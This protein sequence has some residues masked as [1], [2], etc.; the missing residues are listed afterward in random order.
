VS[1]LFTVEATLLIFLLGAFVTT[2]SAQELLVLLSQ[3]LKLTESIAIFLV[4]S[5]SESASVDSSSDSTTVRALDDFPLYGR[6][7][8]STS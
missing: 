3:I 8:D 6:A 1:K 4:G 7:I 5:S 2:S